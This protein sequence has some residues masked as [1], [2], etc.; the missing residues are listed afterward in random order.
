[1]ERKGKKD[2]NGYWGKILMADLS[3]GTVR[4]EEIEEPFYRKHLGG[5]GLAVKVLWDRMPPKADPLGPENL[6]GFAT[7][8]L[9][10]TGALF[11]GRFTVTGKSPATEGWGDANCGGYFSPFL[12]RCG[13]DA[14]FFHGQSANPVYL[15]LDEDSAQLLDASPL[16]GKD[17][18]D[19]EQ[20]LKETHGK[21]AQV[22][23]I[24]PGGER[25]SYMGGICNDGGRMAGRCG[26]G[27]VMG[28]KRLK[29]VVANGKRRV[30]V[31][32][33]ERIKKLSREFRDRLEGGRKLKRYMG[34][35]L[36]GWMGKLTRMGPVYSRQPADLF[37]LMLSKYG[38]ASMTALSAEGGD[39]PVKNWA[40][41]GYVDF[42]LERSQR[43]G[44]DTLSNYEIRKYG[45]YS[46]PLQ[47]GALVRVEDGP[48]PIQEMHRPEYETLC[49]FGALLLNDDLPTIFRV[50]DLLNRAGLDTISCGT[51]VAFATECFERGILTTRDT[52]GLELRWGASEAIVKLTEMIIRREGLG[53]I[54]ADGVKIA[55][56]KIGGGADAYAVH[57][58]GMEPPM[59]DPKFDPGF[60]MAYLCEPTPSRHMVSSYMLLD[61]ERLDRRFKRAGKPP[62][63]M[64]PKERFRYDNKG[65]AMAMGAFFRM[66]LDSAGCCVFGTQVGG[67]IPLV[68]WLN[69]ATGWD[70]SE[71]EYLAIGERVEQLRHAFNVREGINP[72][73]DF[74]MHPRMCGDPPLAKGPAKRITLDQDAMARAYYEA[75]GWDISTG[76]PHRERLERLGLD[77][78]IAGLYRNKGA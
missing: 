8:L 59:H 40:G 28:A 51:A 2:G 45:C 48:Y 44:P 18:V 35:R 34:D 77:E 36:L 20:A 11:T 6:L 15:Y 5:L 73:R 55:A 74:R 22:A 58:G 42:P 66:L 68:E 9:T 38:T 71:E 4:R 23:C 1:M 41:V 27:A 16:W 54:L 21:L 25:L 39:S 75:M 7:G 19:T 33:P 24:G 26:L 32:E 37:R 78:V 69:S 29:A 62:A 13:V 52:D 63:F 49:A 17:T 31:A 70:L 53:D 61:L 67:D 46:C 14:V 56:Q 65:D 60:G 12:K 10:D 64:T 30:G 47:C 3:S 72:V 50:N 57:C 76:M 43:I